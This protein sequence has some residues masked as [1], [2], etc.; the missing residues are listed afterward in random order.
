MLTAKLNKLVLKPPQD[1]NNSPPLGYITAGAGVKLAKLAN[2]ATNHA[3]TGLEFAQAIPGSVGGAIYMNAGAYDHDI[4]GVCASVNVL[5]KGSSGAYEIKEI[6]G[7]DMEFGYRT[8]R[9]QR[10]GGFILDAV[11]RLI[12]GDRE[13]IRATVKDLNDK[14]REKQ[15]HQPSAGSAFKRPPGHYA[16]KLIQDAGCKGLQIGGA[17]IS[18]KHAGFVI[19]TGDATARDVCLL[20]DEVRRRVHEMSGVWLESEIKPL[21]HSFPWV[22]V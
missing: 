10:E 6:R 18:E 15:P 22:S 16:G 2:T 5:T 8:S 3:L 17:Q 12:P 19:N 21:G 13:E 11:F 9:I 1:E 7:V 4:A 14:R 20:M